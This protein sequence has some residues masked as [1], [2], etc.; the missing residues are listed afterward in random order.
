MVLIL[1][2]VEDPRTPCGGAENPGRFD[3]ALAAQL[4]LAYEP[5]TRTQALNNFSQSKKGH[6]IAYELIFSPPHSW[7]ILWGL[8][9]PDVRDSMDTAY[10]AAI[11]STMKYVEENISY[12]R[13]G[14]N[15]VRQID[16]D[17][18]WA[19]FE[20]FSDRH[21]RPDRHTHVLIDTKVRGSD[22]QWGHL[23]VRPLR[24]NAEANTFQAV[25][26]SAV[27]IHSR[28]AVG[29]S[30]EERPP[31]ESGEKPRLEVAGVPD[32]LIL[33]FFGKSVSSWQDS[34]WQFL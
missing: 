10:T 32:E 8:S 16:A 20:H 15:G 26:K 34:D 7:S 27:A 4:D 28:N 23:D 11:T 13:R 24:N 17:I 3:G 22:G 14:R 29:L 5:V 1:S 9:E 12:T 33:K 25:F 30:L 2:N 18:L 31:F 19:Q 6:T 21:R